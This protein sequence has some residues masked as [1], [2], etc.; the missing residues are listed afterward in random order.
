MTPKILRE[1]DRHVGIAGKIEVELKRERDRSQPAEGDVQR[2][3]VGCIR[4]Q[5]IRIGRQRVGDHCLL[6][7]TDREDHEADHHIPPDEL[8][9]ERTVDLGN[10]LLVVGDRARDQLR[11]EGGEERKVE[12]TASAACRLGRCR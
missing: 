3:A 5:G 11:E 2:L 9:E 6:E 1:A 8:A 12:R 7:E 10:D 4:E